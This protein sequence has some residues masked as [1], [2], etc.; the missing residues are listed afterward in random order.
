MKVD[1]QLV[2]SKYNGKCA[3]CGYDIDI[4]NMQVDHCISQRNFEW[5]IKNSFKIP[6]H[7]LHLG[8]NGL[9]HVDNLMPT[10]RSC[11]NFKSAFDLETFRKEIEAQ[12]DRFRKYK[13]MFNLAEKYGLIE[14]KS[15]PIVFYF[16]TLTGTELTIK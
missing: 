1:R 8:L 13:P 6:P 9:H 10:C 7:L 11:N 15:K 12:V 14:C 4:K 3:Y 2:H 5:H 16:E